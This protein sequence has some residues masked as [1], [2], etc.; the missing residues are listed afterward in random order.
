MKSGKR[1]RAEFEANQDE[2]L[3]QKHSQQPKRSKKCVYTNSKFIKKV[4]LSD[5]N[6]LFRCIQFFLNGEDC[7]HLNCRESVIKHILDNKKAYRDC[8][9]G[10]EES[11]KKEMENMKKNGIWGTNVELYAASELYAFNFEIYKSNSLDIYC[12]CNHSDNFPTMSLEYANENHF[13]LL[14]LKD[15]KTMEIESNKE[16]PSKDLRKGK[17]KLVTKNIYKTKENLERIINQIKANVSKPIEIAIHK[18]VKKAH[19]AIYPAGRN[20][21]NIYN[22]IFQYYSE[23]K[24]PERFLPLASNKKRFNNWVKDIK[25]CYSL[26]KVSKNK[27]SLSRL[28]F[29]NQNKEEFIIPYED[30]IEKIMKAS[31][32]S[33]VSN[34][35]KHFGIKITT[36]N[37]KLQGFHW[38]NMSGDIYKYISSCPDCVETKHEPPLKEVKSIIPNA[39]LERLQGDLIHLSSTQVLACNKNYNY[40]FSIVDHFSKFKWCFA[41]KEKSGKTIEKCLQSVIATFG[42]PKIFQTDNGKEFKNSTL[43]NFLD[44]QKIE[45]IN[46]SVRH[47]QSQG[48]VERHNRELKL[49][50][51]KAL[52]EFQSQK[53]SNDDWNLPL[54]LETF[55][56]R[57]NNRF[58]TVTKQSPNTIIV[59]KDKKLLDTVRENIENHYKKNRNDQKNKVNDLLKKGTKVFI[60][61][62][63]IP[64]RNH[65]K[66]DKPKSSKVEKSKQKLKLCAIVFADYRF[67]D[68]SVKIMIK[69]KKDLNLKLENIYHIHPSLL[70]VPSE[71]S[72]DIILN[73]IVK[74][75]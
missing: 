9:E 15:T 4:I 19:R 22:E 56:V 16:R 13:N 68:T 32:Q 70:S 23:K 63:V 14:F 10:G 38:A 2:T 11:L 39:P 59:S 43:K 55:R 61:Q 25:K 75:N 3:L 60:I 71:K 8:F 35:K 58:H 21:S 53:E 41:I 47:P 74:N 64:N 31:H 57:E 49:Y 66:L 18:Q 7:N 45:Y 34:V 20:N 51:Q 65:T 26:D 27:D 40:V 6:C 46:G 36:G 33:L 72:W 29:K 73:S 24:I 37:I 62:H 17:N 1:P 50:L 12:H 5:G 52:N 30:E 44:S 69:M 48:L 42:I 28:C 67:E 54:D